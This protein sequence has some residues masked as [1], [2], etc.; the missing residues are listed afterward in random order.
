MPRQKYILPVLILLNTIVLIGQLYP[1]G[2]PPFARIVN[3]VFLVGSLLFFV[4]LIRQ[5]QRK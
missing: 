2:A 5:K 3:I 1:V 4:V